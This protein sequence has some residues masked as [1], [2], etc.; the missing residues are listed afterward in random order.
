MD[1]II[2]CSAMR[3]DVAGFSALL[4]LAA[5]VEGRSTVLELLEAQDERN[6]CMDVLGKLLD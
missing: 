1:K 4:V 5:T 3:S 6:R 2:N